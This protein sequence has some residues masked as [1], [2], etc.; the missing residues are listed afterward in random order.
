MRSTAPLFASN[1]LRRCVQTVRKIMM[2]RKPDSTVGKW[3]GV[4]L[5]SLWRSELLRVPELV[6]VAELRP[7]CRSS[8]IIFFA[9]LLPQH[10]GTFV[11]RPSREFEIS[12][13]IQVSKKMLIPFFH[14]NS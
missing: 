8:G 12:W 13:F 2:V 10:T 5:P 4:F 14:R 11:D 7:P 1:R 6:D 9:E 3:A